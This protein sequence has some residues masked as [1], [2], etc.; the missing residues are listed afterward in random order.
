MLARSPRSGSSSDGSTPRACR[1][2]WT[3]A[4]ARSRLRAVSWP[5]ATEW[6]GHS[7]CPGYDRLS[8]APTAAWDDRC[9]KPGKRPGRSWRPRSAALP[10][11]AALTAPPV[12]EDD[13]QRQNAKV[14]RNQSLDVADIRR[15]RHQQQQSG[16]EEPGDVPGAVVD[17]SSPRRPRGTSAGR[18]RCALHPVLGIGSCRIGSAVRSFWHIDRRLQPIR[19]VTRQ[20]LRP[21]GRMVDDRLR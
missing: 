5:P 15:A 4:G 7:L 14:M 13:R 3:P 8:R 16:D 18:R 21:L 17:C 11:P 9:S 2:R 10:K 6:A 19:A 1:A 20:R 12:A